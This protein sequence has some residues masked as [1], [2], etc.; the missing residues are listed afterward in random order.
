[1]DVSLISG[2]S[3]MSVNSYRQLNDGTIKMGKMH[4]RAEA[5]LN[6]TGNITILL[7]HIPLGDL[8]LNVLQ[9]GMTNMLEKP[10]SV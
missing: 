9:T 2:K 4:T 1:M 5:Q 7:Y 8:I 3:N 6:Q 10:M